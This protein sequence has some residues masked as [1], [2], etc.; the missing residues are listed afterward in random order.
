MLTPAEG[1]TYWTPVPGAFTPRTM[2]APDRVAFADEVTPAYR[3]DGA[4]AK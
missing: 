1:L 3:W 2:A 4:A